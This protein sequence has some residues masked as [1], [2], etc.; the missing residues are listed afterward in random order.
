MTVGIFQS[1]DTGMAALLG[2]GDW[3]ANNHYAML[4]KTAQIVDRTHLTRADII[5]NVCIDADY[6]NVDLTGK[7]ITLVAQKTRFDCNKILF[8]SAVS[9]SGRFIYILNGTAAASIDGDIIVGCI[10]LNTET[11]DVA[12]LAAEFSYEPATSGLF[13]ISRT[14]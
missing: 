12:S 7:A 8:G 13:E 2:A 11:G 4:I 3:A 1:H 5:A 10:D 9:I 6:T 14:A